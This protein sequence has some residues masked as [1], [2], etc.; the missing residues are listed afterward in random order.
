MTKFITEKFLNANKEMQNT[1][2]GESEQLI[3]IGQIEES[4]LLI[5]KAFNF[6]C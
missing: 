4:K 2:L 1:E 3:K 6:V 5:N